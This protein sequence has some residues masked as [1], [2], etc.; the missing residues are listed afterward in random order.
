VTALPHLL[1]EVDGRAAWF[2]SRASG[3]VAW[4]LTVA[5][6]CWGL[7]FSAKLIRKK[8]IPAWLAD[9]HAFLGTLTLVFLGVHLVALV[10]DSYTRFGPLELFVPMASEWKPGPV[11]WG[12][13][14]MY[15]LVVVQVTSW[16]RL[17]LPRRL[18][19]A[20]H[21]GSFAVLG[22][23]TV[24]GILSGTDW[25]TGAAMW[26]LALGLGFTGASV[27]ARLVGLRRIRAKRSARAARAAGPRGAVAGG[28]GTGGAP[29][30]EPAVAASPDA[31][32]PAG[33]AA[34]APAPAPASTG[35]PVLGPPPFTGT[36]EWTAPTTLPPPLRAR[37]PPV[38]ETV[39]VG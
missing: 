35:A 21:L 13:V 7:T 10:A 5:A 11:T 25:D 16:L 33:S 36:V 27:I 12:I 39:E 3:V 24:H 22:T 32:V 9:L 1:A 18:W 15:L 20:V 38:A 37:R 28:R 17:R 30:A 29:V 23:A 4:M 34:S 14:A 31:P 19:H 8:G 26:V 2:V 6:I